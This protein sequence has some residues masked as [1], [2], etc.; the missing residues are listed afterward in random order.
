MQITG[1][2]LNI[3]IQI[4]LCYELRFIKADFYIPQYV[5]TLI[6]TEI[7]GKYRAHAI[8]IHVCC[9]CF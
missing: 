7:K 3:Q 5:I 1:I 2:K 4:S 8:S 6:M 9:F